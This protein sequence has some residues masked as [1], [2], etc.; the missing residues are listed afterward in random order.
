LDC[1]HHGYQKPF[2]SWA[3]RMTTRNGSAAIPVAQE[4]M[5]ESYCPSM[6]AARR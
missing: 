4:R 1:S 3:N 5:Y 6:M 2:I